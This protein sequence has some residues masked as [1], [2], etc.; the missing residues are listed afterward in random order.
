MA[1]H[2]RCRP[3]PRPYIARRAAQLAE[4][5]FHR[6]D[7]KPVS[8]VI[9]AEI[10]GVDLRSLDDDTFAEIARAHRDYRVIFFRD[11]HLD[12][13]EQI[14]F[15]QRFGELEEH[16]FLPAADGEE[17]VIRF[18]KSEDVVGVENM[19]HSDVSWRQIPSLGSVLQAIEVPPV[20]GDTLF[21]DM[22]AAYECLEPDV[23]E[24]IDDLVAV[25]D[26]VNSFG[27]AMKPE[28][29]EEKR[30]EFPPAEHPVV[31]T[32]PETGEK[33]IYVNPIFT[34][35]IV[36]LPA[37]ESEELLT[38]LY[39]QADFPE[40]QC[41]FRWEPGS[42]AFWDNRMVQHYAANDYWPNRRVM[43]R[44]TVIGERPA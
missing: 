38:M 44:V 34:S 36:G 5:P 8:P 2:H 16:P 7:V 4:R 12:V 31:R 37:D 27:M 18:E 43:E 42:I 33:A 19:W 25:H 13:R 21:S 26:F 22:V 11:Q 10:G 9:G 39:E 35:H 3:G 28:E 14:E 41:R 15:A 40:Y 24:R 23:K 32:H 17:E 6:I 20:G 1:L 30:K 29:R